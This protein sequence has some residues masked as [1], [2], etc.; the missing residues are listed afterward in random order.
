MKGREPED[1]AQSPGDGA[2]C[3][4]CGKP[5][6]LACGERLLCA[7]C[8]ELLGSCCLEFGADDLW[9]EDGSAERKPDTQ[10][11]E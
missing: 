10:A 1:G 4:R 11:D 9:A 5:E 8:R 2:V 6:A 7:E 3:E